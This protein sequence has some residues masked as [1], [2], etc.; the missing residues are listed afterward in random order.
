MSITGPILRVRDGIGTV[1]HDEGD[2][3][4]RRLFHR[5]GHRPHEGVDARADVLDVEHQHVHVRQ[6]RGRGPLRAVVQRVDGDARA[7]VAA[8]HEGGA[9]LQVAADAVL[10]AKQR[11]QPHA[12]GARQHVRAQLAGAGHGA[13]VGDEPHALAAHQVHGIAQQHLDPRDHRVRAGLGALPGGARTGVGRR[14]NRPRRLADCGDDPV[15]QA[16]AESTA[17][18]RAAAD[19]R[20][21]CD[22]GCIVRVALGWRLP[23]SATRGTVTG[24]RR[25]LAKRAPP[26]DGVRKRS[27]FSSGSRFTAQE[28]PSSDERPRR[29]QGTAP[30]RSVPL[31]WEAVSLH[32]LCEHN[33]HPQR[34]DLWRTI[35]RGEGRPDGGSRDAR[36]RQN[37]PP[38]LEKRRA[39]HARAPKRGG[40]SGRERGVLRL[41]RA[42]AA[43]AVH[44]RDTARQP[45]LLPSML[46]LSSTGFLSSR[47]TP[48]CAETRGGRV[49]RA[50]H[51][52]RVGADDARDLHRVQAVGA[53][54]TAA[55]YA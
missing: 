25:P 44:G 42:A 21:R 50:V 3:A 36:K 15:R 49:L 12:G 8:A 37:R 54:A 26:C 24:R 47:L 13:G 18:S 11:H 29:T 5:H 48:S 35:R 51:R 20:W 7:G 17:S 53:S 10:R 28:G 27:V 39:V 34:R 2:A 46:E 9:R 31:L 16:P 30:C 52:E 32:P 45:Q 14:R 1:Q 38:L 6:L 43:G 22:F 23:P 55:P 4:L 41:G 40:R 33:I 19:R